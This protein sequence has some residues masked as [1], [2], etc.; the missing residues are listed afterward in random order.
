MLQEN[1]F[2]NDISEFLAA[3]NSTWHLIPAN[4]PHFI[5]LCEA[6]VK[7]TKFHLNRTV[8]NSSLTFEEM[9]T[10]LTQIESCLN[11]RPLTK[12]Y[13]DPTDPSCLTPA[14]F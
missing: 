7:S 3:E 1:S 5:G 14:Y 11:S 12:L 13:D 8:G 2:N 6:A 10:L 4:A 9:T